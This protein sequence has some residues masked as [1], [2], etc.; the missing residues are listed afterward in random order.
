[1]AVE[2]RKYPWSLERYRFCL[3][4]FYFFGFHLF[5]L[6]IIFFY[7]KYPWSLERYNFHF[8]FLIFLVLIF[9]FYHFQSGSVWH[10]TRD[11]ESP[12]IEQVKYFLTRD[13]VFVTRSSWL[14]CALRD[15]QAVYWV[16]SVWYS[17]GWYLV[18][19][20]QYKVILDNSWWPS[21]REHKNWTGEVNK[22]SLFPPKCQ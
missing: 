20:C 22:W 6:N 5:H 8:I 1:M 2:L 9:K 14:N 11:E 3:S 16:M 19:L 21:V 18:V 10:H 17:N 4:F 12:K 13:P 7:K 15:D